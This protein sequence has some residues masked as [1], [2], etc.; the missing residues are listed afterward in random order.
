MWVVLRAVMIAIR[1]GFMSKYRYRL[2]RKKILPLKSI[3]EDL[4]FVVWLKID[5][6]TFESE[7]KATFF[8]LS[9]RD[10]QMTTFNFSFCKQLNPFFDK[11]LK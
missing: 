1:Y 10:D 11:R 3:K 5:P 2:V 9:I 4:L 8:R 6:D 7:S